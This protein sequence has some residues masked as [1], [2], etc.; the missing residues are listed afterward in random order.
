MI[1]TRKQY[2][3]HIK[4]PPSVNHLYGRNGWRT[5][6]KPQGEAWFTENLYLLKIRYGGIQE[7]I[8]Y[9]QVTLHYKTIRGDIDNV[10]KGTLDLLTKS[11][12]ILDDQYIM[13]LIITKEI[14]HHKP[15][16]GLD[17]IVEEIYENTL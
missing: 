11:G 2:Q 10:L 3:F 15:D 9:A 7:P 14:V 17:I 4:R 1:P 16:E 12:M 6:I 13:K 5:Y 8:K